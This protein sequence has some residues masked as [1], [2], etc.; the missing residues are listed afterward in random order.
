MTM[1]L[2][3]IFA[4]FEIASGGALFEKPV[5]A[6]T[7]NSDGS[8][9]YSD[10]MRTDESRVAMFSY[11]CTGTATAKVFTAENQQLKIIRAKVT[12]Y[13]SQAK[14]YFLFNIRED[15]R[16]SEGHVTLIAYS[17]FYSP[18]PGYDCKVSRV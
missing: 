16:T 13:S 9:L 8:F 1:E 15:G 11:R 17:V 2:I 4:I 3:C 5:I 10:T 12:G 6:A 7:K 14:R 18:R